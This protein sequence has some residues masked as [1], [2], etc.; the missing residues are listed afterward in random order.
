MSRLV[1]R[2]GVIVEPSG[3]TT[4]DVAIEVARH[5]HSL[6]V[7]LAAIREGRVIV[8]RDGRRRAPVEV[9]IG[10]VNGQWAEILNEVVV[11]GDEVLIQEP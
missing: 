7:P 3:T 4:A 5:E 8:R 2:G 9:R 10:A 6:M 11:P 1:I